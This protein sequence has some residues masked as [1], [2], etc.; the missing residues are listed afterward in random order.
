MK[1]VSINEIIS[2]NK[3]VYESLAIQFKNKIKI[4]KKNSGIAVNFFIKYFNNKLN[5]NI[6][7]LGPGS[8]Y[9][10]KLFVEKGFKTT[11][12]EFSPKMAAIC[13]ETSPE[14]EVIIDE[15]LKHNFGK[16]KYSGVITLAFIHLFPR[17]KTRLV[18]KKI[19]KLLVP[20]GLAFITTT[21][22]D[23]SEE[24]FL[25]KKNFRGKFPR[26]RRKFTEEE[27]NRELKKANMTV[28]AKNY[29]RDYEES[30]KLWMDYVLK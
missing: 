9:V 16:K 28:V 21:K 8:G 7:E 1:T 17:T 20:G 3:K 27:F 18:L 11:A 10:C 23:Y 13:K 2:T 15:F 26:F 22:H 6:I 30:G 5:K 4:R 14:T 12:I 19:K 25:V 24:G 29:V